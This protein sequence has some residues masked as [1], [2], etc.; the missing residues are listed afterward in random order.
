MIDNKKYHIHTLDNG[1]RVVAERSAGNVSYIGAL[2]NAGSRDED[3]QHCGLAHFVEHTVFKGTRHRRSY[4]ISSRMETIGG[5]LNAYTTKEE[6]MIYT[7]APAGYAARSLD[8]IS[9]LI[10]NATFPPSEIDKEKE[11]IVEEIYSYR[12]SPSDSVFDEFEELIYAGSGLAHNIL[13][14]EDSVKALTSADGRRFID[15]NYTPENIVIY[16]SDPSDPDKNIRLVEKYFGDLNFKAALKERIMPDIVPLFDEQRDRHNHQANCITGCRLFGRNDPRRHAIFLLNNYLGGPC[17]NS[18]LNME[19]RDR[20][21]LVYT[22]ESSVALMSDTG[23]LLIYYGCDPRQTSKCRSII[24]NEID[25]LA[26]A[27]LPERTFA[28]IRDQYC[29]QLIMSGEHRESRAMSMAKSLLYY[30]DIHDITFT[31]DCIRNLTPSDL[32]QAAQLIASQGLSTL[33][34]R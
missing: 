25:R 15:S 34:L 17:M 33:T 12:D 9:D 18:R 5:E 2:V 13:G 14:N 21:G 29:G 32:Q 16:C 30:D 6:T 1:L 23:L 28:R 31:A 11:V 3:L 22:V 27:P 19:M 20:R 8:L 24:V 4:H 7:N 26:Q 10:K